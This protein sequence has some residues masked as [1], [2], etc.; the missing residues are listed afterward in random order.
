MNALTP[1]TL[2]HADKI[3]KATRVL[4]IEDDP[5]VSEMVTQNLSRLGYHVSQCFDGVSGLTQAMAEPYQLI[6]LDIMLPELNGLSLLSRLRAHRNTP[7]IVLS[8]CGGEQDRINGFSTGADDYL[9]KPFSM[10]ELQLRIEAILRRCYQEHKPSNPA[11]LENE[12]IKLNRLDKSLKIEQQAIEIT[13]VEFEL[14][15]QLM[16]TPEETLSRPYL[17]QAVLNR[18]YSRYDRSLDMHISNIRQKL[19]QALPSSD[20]IRTI[21][22]KGYRY[23]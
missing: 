13:P 17:Y 2:L 7:V 16:K 18:S 12:G 5:Q 20:F 14:L 21:R 22:G 10:Q 6:L 4:L 15:W 23:Q 1:P 11:Q 3:K 8:A 19:K 9:P